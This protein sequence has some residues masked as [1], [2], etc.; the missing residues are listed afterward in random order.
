MRILA[1]LDSHVIWSQNEF[2]KGPLAC[3]IE[4]NSAIDDK[5]KIRQYNKNGQ[6]SYSK[7]YESQN[8]SAKQTRGDVWK[9]LLKLSFFGISAQAAS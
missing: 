9:Q 2:V 6:G 8:N 1:C 3:T 7:H 5:P 4:P